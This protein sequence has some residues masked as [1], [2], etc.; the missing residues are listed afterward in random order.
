VYRER[1]GRAPISS[2]SEDMIL[3]GVSTIARRRVCCAD[4]RSRPGPLVPAPVS[5]LLVSPPPSSS[6][7]VTI[8]RWPI[9]RHYFSTRSPHTGRQIFAQGGYPTTA[10]DKGG[11]Y[12]IR[13]E[14]EV[15][16]WGIEHD[17]FPQ[18]FP[19]MEFL[20]CICSSHGSVCCG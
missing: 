20:T 12:C 9:S 14:E 8:H 19:G 2:A 16:V 3:K 7:P 6:R 5:L 18:L 13:A 4:Q 1:E 11:V 10:S 15:L 17:E